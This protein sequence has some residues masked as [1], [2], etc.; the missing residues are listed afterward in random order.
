MRSKADEYRLNAVNCVAIAE[1]TSDVATRAKLLAMAQAWR[2]LA[3]QAER[4]SQTDLVYETPELSRE[5]A[6]QQ[7]QIQPE[8]K[9]E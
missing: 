9:D 6:Q 2:N 5:V 4:N 7:Q 1:Q 3:D 8:E